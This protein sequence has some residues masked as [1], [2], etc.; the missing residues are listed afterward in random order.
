MGRE[1]GKVCVGGA[2]RG[3]VA[4]LPAAETA[5]F[6]E[7]LIPFLW[8]KFLWSFI[9]VDVHGIGV[10]SGSASSGGGG[11]ESDWSPG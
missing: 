5:S 2:G 4:F 10:P 1:R 6:F 7:T 8:G 3:H 11:M 9:D